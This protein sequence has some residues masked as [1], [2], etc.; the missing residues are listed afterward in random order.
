MNIQHKSERYF[1]ED[2][3]VM[4]SECC[5]KCGALLDYYETNICWFCLQIERD[6]EE[7][8]HYAGWNDSEDSGLD[9]TL[10]AFFAAVSL[11]AKAAVLESRGEA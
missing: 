3:W 7:Q 6:S 2:I 11:F 1:E 10:P 5:Y 4:D 9:V 8:V